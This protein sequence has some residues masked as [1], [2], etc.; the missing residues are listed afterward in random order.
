[1]IWI[2]TV[3]SDL[4]V[5][6]LRIITVVIIVSN[7]A[8]LEF[9]L[10]LYAQNIINNTCTYPKKLKL[11]ISIQLT[12]YVFYLSIYAPISASPYQGLF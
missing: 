11:Y 8:T 12:T 10:D 7:S 6:K 2:C 1:M 4:S 5:L 3:C 9:S